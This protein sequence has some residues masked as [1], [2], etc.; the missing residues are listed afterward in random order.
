MVNKIKKKLM[1]ADSK[2]KERKL[3][4]GQMRTEARCTDARKL[5]GL[6]K[7]SNSSTCLAME[8]YVG[9]TIFFMM[10]QKLSSNLVMSATRPA[11]LYGQRETGYRQ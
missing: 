7:A 6:D 5:A 1:A 4:A 3:A 10:M 2:R 9:H 11:A 8:V